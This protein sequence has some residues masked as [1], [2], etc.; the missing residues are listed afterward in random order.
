MYDTEIGLLGTKAP[1]LLADFFWNLGFYIHIVFGGI[2]LL[3]GWVQ[4]NQRL[5]NRYLSL[6]RTIGRFYVVSALLGALAGFYLGFHA[7][8]FWLTSLGFILLG[9]V[10]FVSTFM[11]YLFILRKKLV[12]HQRM[13]TYSYAAC[14]AAVTLRIWLPLLN[15]IFADFVVAYTLVAWLCWV[16]NLVVAWWLNRSF[17]FSMNR[18]T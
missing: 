8:G 15:L 7:T 5:R 6:H 10:W 3:V 1:G 18:S 11:A 9:T 17:G 13:M 16:P 14:W 4:F 12:Q 2:A